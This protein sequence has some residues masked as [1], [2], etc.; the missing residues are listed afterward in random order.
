[1]LAHE[2]KVLATGLTGKKDKKLHSIR[3]ING[4]GDCP[5]LIL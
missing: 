4:D 3:T 1:M 5:K 2:L